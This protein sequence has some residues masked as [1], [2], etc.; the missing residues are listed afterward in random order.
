MQPV[1]PY[2]PRSKK[3]Y[4]SV[5]KPQQLGQIASK[6]PWK[7]V[8]IEDQPGSAKYKYKLVYNDEDSLP[9]PPPVVKQQEEQ[10]SPETLNTGKTEPGDTTNDYIQK[11]IDKI[12]NTASQS[13]KKEEQPSILSHNSSSTQSNRSLNTDKTIDTQKIFNNSTS[14]SSTRSSFT[15]GKAIS[16]SIT[17]I[18]HIEKTI[19]PINNTVERIVEG[20][21]GPKGDLGPVCIPIQ[22]RGSIRKNTRMSSN[23]FFI[24]SAPVSSEAY[25]VSTKKKSQ[26]FLLDLFLSHGSVLPVSETHNYE[27]DNIAIVMTGLSKTKIPST[28]SIFLDIELCYDVVDKECK[29]VRLTWPVPLPDDNNQLFIKTAWNVSTDLN[30]I[31]KT[32]K[33][34]CKNCESLLLLASIRFENSS[35]K[36]MLS[37][38][39]I[40]FLIHLSI[41]QSFKTNEKIIITENPI[42]PTTSYNVHPVLL[43]KN[44][45]TFIPDNYV[46]LQ[47]NPFL[48]NEKKRQESDIIAH[49]VHNPFFLSYRR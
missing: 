20:P 35:K 28:L 1:S 24:G 18:D 32:M 10:Q 38:N 39:H 22:F 47:Q 41:I 25:M 48:Y 45:D 14:Q 5:S 16:T 13:I 2:N 19:Q 42:T 44:I 21:P 36:S 3:S 33:T 34:K 23:V 8:K 29:T 37:E 49:Q 17:P 12:N 4:N 30:D 31:I 15:P 43:N 27:I 7:L 40:Q 9:R 11:I 26:D 6:N 46:Q